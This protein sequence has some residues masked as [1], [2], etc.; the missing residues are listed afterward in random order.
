MTVK[1]SIFTVLAVILL[2]FSI[3]APAAPPANLRSNIVIDADTIRLGDIFD[4]K[5]ANAEK[6]IAYSP[7]PGRKLILEATW[8]FRVARAYRVRWRPSS[9]LDRAI[10][11]RRS[12]VIETE[13]IVE[14]VLDA[15]REQA[16]IDGEMELELDE[17]AKR[18]YLP[19]DIA[20]VITAR[21][22]SYQR[23]SGRFSAILT[24]GERNF[25]VSGSAHKLVLVPTLSQRIHAGDVIG[26]RDI[27]WKSM[28][29]NRLDSRTVLNDSKLV[30]MSPRRPIVA[31]RA[32]MTTEIQPPTLV[33]RGKR[34]TI[35]LKTK[36]MQLTAKGKSLEN[37]G[38]GDVVRV[39]NVDSGKTIEARVTGPEQ[40]SVF[41]TSPIALN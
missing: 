10:V 34:V 20:P 26:R 1:Q 41:T 18:I 30:G 28:R 7:A 13:Q 19:T 9:R 23:R 27:E 8:L 33:R 32:I 3:P 35:Y 24:A 15:L 29:L 36:I 16:G 21:S 6:V 37:G 12:L 11:E 31:G 39:Q 14:T 38:K 22:L 5:F 17:R 25:T 40:V 2:L 4:G